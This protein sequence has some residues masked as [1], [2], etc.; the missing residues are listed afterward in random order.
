MLVGHVG[1]AIGAHGI[2]KT[3]PLGLLIIASQLPDW[4]D[5]TLCMSGVRSSVPG[6][7]SHSLPAITVLAV[8]AGILTF[9]RSRDVAASSLVGM[10]VASHV[11]GDYFTGIK[12]LWAGGPT[13]G[14]GLYDRPALD[15]VFEAAVITAGW[16]LY[17][18]SFPAER[19]S[20]REVSAVLVVLLALQLGADVVFWLSPGMQKC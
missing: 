6:M 9:A 2:R 4:I 5:A 7:L 12:P 15:F 16:L 13:V 3:L 18:S 17:R 10:V 14:L 19:R 8:V 20:S 11:I 1:V